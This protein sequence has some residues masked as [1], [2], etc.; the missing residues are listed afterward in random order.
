M[1]LS[2]LRS[3]LCFM[4]VSCSAY[5][6]TLKMEAVCSSETSVD[7]HWIAQCYIPEDRTLDSHCCETLKSN[8]TCI[9]VVEPDGSSQSIM[10]AHNK[11]SLTVI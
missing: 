9:V 1:N 8:K 11:I 6:L 7:F 4:L 10:E 5:C 2:I 3:F